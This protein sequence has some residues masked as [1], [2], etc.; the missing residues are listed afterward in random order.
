ML[1]QLPQEDQYLVS[2]YLICRGLLSGGLSLYPSPLSTI[3]LALVI[4]LLIPLYICAGRDIVKALSVVFVALQ[5][6]SMVN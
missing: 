3:I 1:L 2:P 6:T 5:F 4:A